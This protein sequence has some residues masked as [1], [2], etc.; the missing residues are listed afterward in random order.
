MLDHY[1]N[2]EI[3]NPNEQEELPP[4]QNRRTSKCR[5]QFSNFGLVLTGFYLFL[6]IATAITDQQNYYHRGGGGCVISCFDG[7]GTTILTLPALM[8]GWALGVKSDDRYFLNWL[9]VLPA[10]TFTAFL[11]YLVGMGL[12]KLGCY[13]I[14][15]LR[16]SKIDAN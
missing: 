8:V 12:E 13:I 15:R 6:A 16:S 4:N 3:M 10:I 9:Q 11:V 2:R 5:W 7:I 14:R 1:A